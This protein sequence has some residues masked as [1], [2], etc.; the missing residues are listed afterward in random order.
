MIRFLVSGG[1]PALLLRRL[2][3]S[4]WDS[5]QRRGVGKSSRLK[6]LKVAGSVS[7]SPFGFVIRLRDSAS[8]SGGFG[9]QVSGGCPT[10]F[11]QRLGGSSRIHRGGTGVGEGS[12]G[13]PRCDP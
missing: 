4:L 2:G 8:P 6:G 10:L 11:P 13:F 12:L 5:P 9:F 3:G 1:C 7:T